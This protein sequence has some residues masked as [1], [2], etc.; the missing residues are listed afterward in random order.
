MN[1]TS[2]SPRRKVVDRKPS[3]GQ[4]SPAP[5]PPPPP[6]GGVRNLSPADRADAAALSR[7]IDEANA[8]LPEE[9]RENQR[10]RI[11]PAKLARFAESF[12]G[13]AHAAQWSYYKNAHLRMPV[14]DKLI[15]A[16]YFRKRPQ[17]LFA[18]QFAELTSMPPLKSADDVPLALLQQMVISAAHASLKSPGQQALLSDLLKSFLIAAPHQREAIVKSAQEIIGFG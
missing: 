15:A 9:E 3:R 8:A 11:G 17:D 2:R 14:V 13:S 18:W 4:A 6:R 5:P 16:L 12:G 10:T 7:A 1:A